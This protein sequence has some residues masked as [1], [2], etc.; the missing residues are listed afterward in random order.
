MH[1]ISMPLN[2]E[3]HS[4]G[5]LDCFLEHVTEPMALSKEV[6]R[7]AP[8]PSAPG[9][10]QSHQLNLLSS[11]G[12]ALFATSNVPESCSTLVLI[13]LSTFHLWENPPAL[14]LKSTWELP[15]PTLSF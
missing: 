4:Q 15:T 14:G 9:S 3:V 10:P 11:F 13:P 8:W 7:S 12:P 5:L 2:P 6:S 1:E